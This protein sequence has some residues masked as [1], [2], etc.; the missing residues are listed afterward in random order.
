MAYDHLDQ[1]HLQDHHYNKHTGCFRPCSQSGPVTATEAPACR[2]TDARTAPRRCSPYSTRTCLRTGTGSR[3]C[4]KPRPC[5]RRPC[6]CR[7]QSR[8]RCYSLVALPPPT[9]CT[10]TTGYAWNQRSAT[11][12]R[13]LDR[14]SPGVG[15]RHSPSRSDFPQKMQA[16]VHE[17]RV[18]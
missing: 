8:Y 15:C 4:P 1:S 2:T 6:S 7:Y 17:E 14:P 12:A 11:D 10:N 16:V 3:R 13:T 9:A 18:G 5:C